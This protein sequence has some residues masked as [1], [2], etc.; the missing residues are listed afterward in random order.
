VHSQ[1]SQGTVD[2]QMKL[3]P[4]VAQ[5]VLLRA[6][7]P[8]GWVVTKVSSGDVT[9]PV[10]SDGTV[11]LSGRSGELAIRFYVTRKTDHGV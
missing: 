4:R 3:P 6:R 9:F 2:V 8:D 10:E 11:D 7:L 1:L 5:R